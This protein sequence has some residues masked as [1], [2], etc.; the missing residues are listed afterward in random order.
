MPLVFIGLLFAIAVA[1]VVLDGFDIGVGC[2]VL[3]APAELRPRMLS[4]LSPWRDANE[5]WLFLGVGL[6]VS[7]FPLAWGRVM[8]A[9]YLPMCL[10]A[11]GVLLRSV[12]FEMRLRAHKELQGYWLAGFAVGSLVTAL[13]HGVLLA[14]VVVTYQAASG[15]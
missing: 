9:L 8:S 12:A 15:Y 2:L 7:A 5:F 1:A 6:F 10:L 11:L 13:A 3:F 14:Q 4:L